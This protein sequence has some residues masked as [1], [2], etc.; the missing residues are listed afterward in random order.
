MS[1]VSDGVAFIIVDGAAGEQKTQAQ[2]QGNHLI[3]FQNQLALSGF[4]MQEK[5]CIFE[6]LY[7]AVSVC[8]GVIIS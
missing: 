2:D 7:N 6:S 5:Y 3:L 8:Q 1:S 4:K